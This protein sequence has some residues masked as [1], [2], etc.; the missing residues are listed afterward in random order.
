MIAFISAIIFL[1]AI[2]LTGAIMKDKRFELV[3]HYEPTGDQPEAIEKLVKGFTEDSNKFQTLYGVTGSGKTFTASQII[4]RLN[5]P[6]LV[7]APNKTL[8]AQLFAEFKKF[9]PNN[10]VEYFVSFYDYYQ[11]EAYMPTKDLYIAKDFNINEEIE[12]LRNSSTKALAERN[13]VIVVASVSCIYNVGLPETYRDFTITIK[14]GMNIERD[15]FLSRLVEMQYRRNE[16]DFK[17]K[18]FRAKGERV[19]IKPIYQEEGIRVEFF[20]DEIERISIMDPVTGGR[21]EDL[22]ELTIYPSTQYLTK[23]EQISSAIHQIRTDL[24][25]RID[26]FEKNRNF[27]AAERLTQRTNYDLEQLE[28]LGY[29][30]GIENYSLYFDGRFPGDPPYTLMDHFPD[31]FLLI[32]D[33]SHATLPQVR[34]MYGGDFSRKQNLINHGFRLPTAYDNRPLKWEEFEKRMPTTLFVSA[35][36][37]DYELQHSK[38]VAEQIIRPTGLVD[39][40]I[41]VRPSENQ[42]DDLLV[43]IE[44]RIEKKE[45]VLVTTLTKR[46]AEDLSDYFA[47]A[48]LKS[49]YMHSDIDT[50]E[51]IQILNSLRTGEVDV[52][53][54]INLLREG[55][56]LPEVSLVAI[57]DADKQG[58]LR[59]TRSLIQIMGRAARNV[60][61]TVILYADTISDS[62]KEA[63]TENNRRRKKQMKYNKDNNITP[64]TIVKGIYSVLETLSDAASVKFDKYKVDDE[65]AVSELVTMI[66][67][68]TGL[69]NEAA[70]NLEFELAAELRDKIR[71]LKELL[72]I[73][74]NT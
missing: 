38:L 11:P 42:I 6:T 60:E 16:M 37:A 47:K 43:E 62:M 35:T 44:K 2:Y 64:K 61:G 39:P 34:G 26:E 20:G 46:M 49:Q 74:R 72:R 23:E 27:V 15:D 7:I 70:D 1:K 69:M 36:P 54:G 73:E 24:K 68:L 3:T 40:S 65:V 53:V 31:D 5:K 63:I 9:F 25:N 12:K 56:D 58:F 21:L 32:V 13:D 28:E 45:R 22:D 55:L 59:S 8:A 33:E 14:K 57:L 51:R 52:L 66:E 17:S 10:A 48:G 19:E 50:L 67:E 41:D 18:T 4:A 29:C 71:E 30:S